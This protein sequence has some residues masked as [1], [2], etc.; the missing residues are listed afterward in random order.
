MV[1]ESENAL[2]HSGPPWTWH[3]RLHQVSGLIARKSSRLTDEDRTEILEN[4]R[5]VV[6]Q[7]EDDKN[8]DYLRGLR[9]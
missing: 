4:L 1:I 6:S 2:F 3:H 7:I 5:W 9:R 8:W